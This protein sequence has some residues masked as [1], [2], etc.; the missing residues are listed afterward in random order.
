[1][2]NMFLLAG[3]VTLSLALLLVWMDN[4]LANRLERLKPGSAIAHHKETARE[5][6]L[7]GITVRPNRE[8]LVTLPLPEVVITARKCK[9]A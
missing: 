9:G 7:P 6:I 3:T 8:N 5:L 1:M 2:K 4:T